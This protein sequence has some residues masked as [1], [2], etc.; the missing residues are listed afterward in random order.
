MA[1]GFLLLFFGWLCAVAEGG[2][3]PLPLARPGID[4]QQ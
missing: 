1:L 3:S 2:F 4:L